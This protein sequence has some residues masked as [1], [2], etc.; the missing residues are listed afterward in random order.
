[1]EQ[2]LY[3]CKR[4]EYEFT[5]PKPQATSCPVCLCQTVIWKNFKS[6]FL[7]DVVITATKE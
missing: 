3:E 4:C 6:M 1:M 5:L 7:K 2:P